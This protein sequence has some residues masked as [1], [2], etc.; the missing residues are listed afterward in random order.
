[1]SS[2]NNIFKSQ[3]SNFATT[4]LTK[5]VGNLPGML[6]L[7]NGE[8]SRQPA[9][10]LQN[11][12]TKYSTQNLSFPLDVEAGPT[13]GN[14]GHYVMFYINE[15]ENARL[16]MSTPHSAAGPFQ[17]LQ[18]GIGNVQ[19]ETANKGISKVQKVFNTAKNTYETVRDQNI[20][21]KQEHEG[22]NT[23]LADGIESASKQ[24]EDR[25][26]TIAKNKKSELNRRGSYKGSGSTLS[27]EYAPTKRLQTA[28]SM[29]MPTNVSVNYGAQYTDTEIGAGVDLA[30]Q[31]YDQMG[32]NQW[33]DAARTLLDFDQPIKEGAVKLVLATLGAFPGLGGIRESEAA[34]EGRILS[35]RMEL[36]FKGVDKRKFSYTFKMIP[37]SQAEA[38]EI[39][40][41]TSA[42]KMN[43]LPEF[44]GGNRIG[45][46]F[47]VPNTF[48]IQYMY[49]GSENQYL[50]KIATCVLESM[51]VAYGG[52]RYK[53]FAATDDGAPPVETTMTL[54]F[55]EM[56]L[57]TKE[58]V[59][60]GY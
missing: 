13:R 42:F 22:Y 54:N 10:E 15:Q 24:T 29:Y 49:N 12:S 56:E 30:L 28:I 8:K 21:N 47:T 7:T 52:D 39:F 48:D 9:P 37:R 59:Y 11:Y 43:M 6:G 16:S 23:Q 20:I 31:F 34:R 27:I 17:Y 44:V 51:N 41:I 57:I 4:E 55:A 32:G 33:S 14:H 26:A 46:K 19:T 58:R 60:E 5:V 35:N 38:D 2:L 18:N 50:H 40:K 45:R 3:V 53:T 1:M 36:A 25:F